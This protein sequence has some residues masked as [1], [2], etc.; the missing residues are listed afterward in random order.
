MGLFLQIQMGDILNVYIV[1]DRKTLL[2]LRGFILTVGKD[3]FL[4]KLICN[5]HR[6]AVVFLTKLY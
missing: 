5:I 6:T 2:I 1:V 4:Q 3:V